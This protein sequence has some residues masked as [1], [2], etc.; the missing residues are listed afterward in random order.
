MTGS[1][2]APAS[3]SRPGLLDRLRRRLWR[4]V[5]SSV[6]SDEPVIAAQE[7]L[8]QKLGYRFD[9]IHNLRQALT[10]RSHVHVT[11]MDRLQSNERLEFLGD[12]VLGLVVN[13][14]LY[15]EFEGKEE[16]DLTKIKSL[17]VC[18]AT[19]ARVGDRLGLGEHLFLSRSEAGTGGRKRESILA[20][21]TEAVIG[22]IYLDGGLE[23]AR[24]FI[25]RNILINVEA[26]LEEGSHRNYKSLLQETLQARYKV[27]PRYRVTYTTGPDHARRFTVKVSLKGAVLGV[28]SGTSKKQAEQRAAESALSRLNELEDE[29]TLPEP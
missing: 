27:P 22:A 13:E 19:L 25:S 4:R 5:T 15:E 12:A 9:D 17:L 28:G 26:A 20:D 21:A 8:E 24:E 3:E 29:G 18:G 7:K 2:E 10:H 6:G 1:Q 14:F 11:G 16:G 23:K